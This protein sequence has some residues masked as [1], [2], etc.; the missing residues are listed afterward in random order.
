LSGAQSMPMD[1]D[2]TKT[3]FFSETVREFSSPQNWTVD[4]A[5]DLS[6]WV[7]GNPAVTSVA[8]TEAAGGKITLTG[9]GTD[10]WNNSDQFT[11]AYKTLNGDGSMTARVVSIGPGTNTW[12]KAGVMIRDS[13]DG[14]STHAMM[15][16]TANSDGSAGNG[17]SFQW[18]PA[19]DGASSNS[20]STLV[21]KP[22]YWV[23][24]DRLGDSLSGSYSAD[25]TTWRSLGVPQ[26]ITMGAP[27]YIGLCVTSHQAGEQRTFEFDSITTMGAV[28]GAWQGAI[29]TSPHHNSPESLYVVVEDSAG[30]V[31]VVTHPDPAVTTV[32][33]WTQWRIPLSNFTGVNLSK[34]RKMYIGVGDRTTG[35]VGPQSAGPDLK[36][37]TV[38]AA[39]TPGSVGTLYFDCF[40]LLGTSPRPWF[41]GCVRD[42]SSHNPI[43]FATVT[44]VR[45]DGQVYPSTTPPN[46]DGTY[47]VVVPKGYTYTVTAANGATYASNSFKMSISA[48]KPCGVTQLTGDTACVWWTAQTSKCGA[49]GLD[50]GLKKK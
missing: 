48:G 12:A 39:Q 8:I 33:D 28:T 7:R 41:K 29:I 31:T 43:A 30:K 2:N 11:F 35:P 1:Y 46:A 16:M 25:G 9:D 14:A 27:V 26:V 49:I 24:I 10:I 18:R 40:S 38:S 50:I 45:A 22:P 15:V 13:L 42:C 47:S 19:A 32:T 4:E 44:F 23:K 20:D 5:T 3:P 6:L 36:G 34:V 21:V 17:A 37:V